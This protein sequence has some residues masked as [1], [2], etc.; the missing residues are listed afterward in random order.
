[1]VSTRLNQLALFW[2]DNR[3]N[4]RFFGISILR[5]KENAVFDFQ[6]SQGVLNI[7]VY[8]INIAFRSYFI[9]FLHENIKNIQKR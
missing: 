7:D 6:M 9:A 8:W 2:A 4:G 5:S 3:P 1:M